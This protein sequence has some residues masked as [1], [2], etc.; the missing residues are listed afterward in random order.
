M[1]KKVKE[2]KEDEKKVNKRRGDEMEVKKMK[3]RRNE[4]KET[5]GDEMEV[6]KRRGMK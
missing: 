5:K 1:G 4:N 6:K 3:R 2:M